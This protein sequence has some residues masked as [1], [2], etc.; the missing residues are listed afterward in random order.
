MNGDFATTKVSVDIQGRVQQGE[1]LT[2]DSQTF[3]AGDVIRMVGRTAVPFSDQV[4]LGF[5]EDS[6]CTWWCK[7]ARPYVYASL[8]GTTC[9]TPLMGCETYVIAASALITGYERVSGGMRV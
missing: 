8:T 2:T 3:E 1:A 6:R 9:P 7:L 5:N 4:I